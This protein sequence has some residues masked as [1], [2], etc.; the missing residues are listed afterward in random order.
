MKTRV[1]EVPWNGG[2]LLESNQ[3]SNHPQRYR[4]DRSVAIIVRSRENGEAPS[5]HTGIG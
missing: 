2:S 3:D 1:I 4:A 5:Q